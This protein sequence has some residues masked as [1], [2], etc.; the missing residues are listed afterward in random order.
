MNSVGARVQ[1]WLNLAD[2]LTY[3]NSIFSGVRF[4]INKIRFSSILLVASTTLVAAT[5]V[6]FVV[7]TKADNLLSIDLGTGATSLIGAI[8]F[9]DVEALSFQPGTGVLFGLDDS[10]DQ[11]ITIDTTT[12]AGT[13]VGSL[14]NSFSDAALAFAGSGSSLFGGSDLG[15]NGVYSIDPNTGA[16]TFLSDTGNDPF[17]MAFLNGVM[18]GVSD[19]GGPDNLT[20]IDLVTGV[21]ME[22]GDLGISGDE[23][24]LTFD[25]SGTLWF[26]DAGADNLYTIDF[27]TGAASAGAA[28]DCRPD[29]RLEGLAIDYSSP[30]PVP[31]PAS[32]PL[33]VAGLV[34]LG[35]ISRRRRS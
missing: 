15:D 7:D 33:L 18:Y 9:G 24:D 25:N 28:I 35:F 34:G 21:S 13:A 11:L 5:P 3:K 4:V 30:A 16:A 1:T 27:S 23:G 10:S 26:T 22:V 6:A 20:T 14:G 12:G 32:L 17:A 31:V 29:C 2:M 8:G 19:D